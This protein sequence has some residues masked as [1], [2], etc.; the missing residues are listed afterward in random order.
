M[1]EAVFNVPVGA[2]GF[3]G[4]PEGNN[5]ELGDYPEFGALVRDIVD[6]RSTRRVQI[7]TGVSH[8]T[9]GDM[10]KGIRPKQGTI[11]LFAE[12]MGV[13]PNPLLKAA[14]Y[15]ELPTRPMPTPKLD[16]ATDATNAPRI[17]RIPVFP[18]PEGYNDLD[19]PIVQAAAAGAEE[20]YKTTFKSIADALRHARRVSPGTVM[21]PAPDDDED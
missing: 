16:S 21:G 19:D 14:G 5:E 4:L 13:D 17:E 20:A 1:T 6:G 15:P 11:R 3:M 18:M 7:R 10:I 9:I 8:T 12:G 2:M